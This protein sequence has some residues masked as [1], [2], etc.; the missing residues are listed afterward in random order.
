MKFSWGV[1]IDGLVLGGALL[2]LVAG[3]LAS[4]GQPAAVATAAEAVK[5]TKTPVNVQYRT[6]DPRRPPKEMPQ[7]KPPEAALCAAEFL[8]TAGLSGHAVQTDATHAKFTVDRAE[9]T[10]QLNVTIWLPQNPP[11]TIVEHEEGHRQIAEYFYENADAIAK[12]LAE[13]YLGKAIELSGRDLQESASVALKKAGTE[14]TD[15]LNKEMP[16]ELT[17][18]R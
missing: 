13:P 5:I 3:R 1:A 4:A 16:I 10:L 17:E 18:V 7:L 8:S 14:I 6:F 15:T 2:I 12:R 9:V 11:R